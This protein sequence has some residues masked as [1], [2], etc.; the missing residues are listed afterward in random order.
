VSAAAGGA[1][2]ADFQ[3]RDEH[4]KS[5]IAFHL[6][7]EL[8]EFIADELGDLAAAQA[9]HVDVILSQLALVVVAFAVDV[10]EVELVDEAVALEQ[11]QGAIDGAAIN[12]GIKA[13]SFAKD[14]A[15]VQVLVGGLDHAQDGAALLGH[16]DAALGEMRLQTAGDFGLR[17]GHDSSLAFAC[18]KWS[19]LRCDEFFRET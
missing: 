5:A 7:F 16:A 9:G 8:I 11:T 18:R 4:V 13:L 12:A 1:V 2:S 14:L 6:L 19:Q 10:H 17:K 15:G 3:A